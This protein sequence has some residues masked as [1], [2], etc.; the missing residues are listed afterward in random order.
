MDYRTLG[1][2]DFKVPVLTLGTGTFGGSNEFFK[3]WGTTGVDEA[4][5]LIAQCLEVGLNM[6]DTANS[7]SSGIAEEILGEVLKPMRASV[8]IATK[9][10]TPIGPGPDDG[11]TS[12]SHIMR[13]VENSLQRLQ[14][15]Y[16]D[17]LYIHEFDARTPIEETLNALDDLVKSGKVRQIGCSNFSGWHLMKSL[18][19]S[20]RENW[21][22]YKAHQ[23]NYSLAVRDYEWE[24]APLAAS[25]GV[26]AIAYSPLGGSALTGKLRRGTAA[27]KSSRLA[28]PTNSL[29]A[30]E[31][32]I[33]Q[34]VDALDEI[35]IRINRPVSQIAL[36]WLLKRPT[37]SSLVFGARDED[38]LRSNL[39]A[40]T[41]ELTAEDAFLLDQASK[42]SIPYP[43]SHQLGYPQFQPK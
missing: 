39:E 34:I 11:G 23:V 35:S 6:F 9:V 43:Y 25:E 12:R 8:L 32:S 42:R 31:E 14:T 27:P 30:G 22:K 1:D 2:S 4:R 19:I 28:A 40:L 10:A 38:Q 13:E 18:S 24:L 20:D 16:I 7:Y 3:A 41:W 17:L 37:I 26:S 15:D 21:A 33:F 5:R 36:N 29:V